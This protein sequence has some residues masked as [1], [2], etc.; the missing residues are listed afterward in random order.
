MHEK[1]PW[2]DGYEISN[3]IIIKFLNLKSLRRRKEFKQIHTRVTAIGNLKLL[4]SCNQVW[5]KSKNQY[6]KIYENS[7]GYTI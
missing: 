2:G 6:S 3:L 1:K 7:P 5:I 4:E